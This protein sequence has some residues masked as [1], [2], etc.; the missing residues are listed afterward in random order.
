MTFGVFCLHDTAF[1]VALNNRINRRNPV[2]LAV[3]TDVVER[4]CQYHALTQQLFCW[5]VRVDHTRV[6]HQFVEE[7]E[8]EQVHDGMFNTTDIDIH[9]Q[10]VVC[11]VRIQHPF[12]ILRAGVA[13]VVP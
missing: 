2:T 9:R 8:V 6:A 3:R 4:I 10:P 5:F 12:L 11:R 13:R 7:A 1:L